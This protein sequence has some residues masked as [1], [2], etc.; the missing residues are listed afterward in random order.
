MV[1]GP[2]PDPFL[3]TFPTVAALSRLRRAV[4]QSS[5]PQVCPAKPMAAAE[6]S[7]QGNGGCRTSHHEDYKVQRRKSSLKMASRSQKLLG[8]GNLK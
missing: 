7:Q 3:D 5:A 6:S 4:A 2:S 8:L 1:E